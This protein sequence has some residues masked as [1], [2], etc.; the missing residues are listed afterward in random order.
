MPSGCVYNTIC[1]R[2]QWEDMNPTSWAVRVR[3]RMAL[4]LLGWQ[5]IANDS[6]E[7]LSQ[8]SLSASHFYELVAFLTNTDALG[9]A[10]PLWSRSISATIYWIA[11]ILF[12]DIHV[13]KRWIPLTLEMTDFL[14][15]TTFRLTFAVLK[16]TVLTT[17]GW[18]ESEQ[19]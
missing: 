9:T 14:P 6:I 1:V 18:I 17:V 15:S 7:P 16:E 4:S 19:I 2:N 8:K 11:M 12:T 3:E 13:P 10:R 5:K